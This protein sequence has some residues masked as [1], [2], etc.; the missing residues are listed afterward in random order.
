VAGGKGAS[1]Q[2]QTDESIRRDASLE[3]LGALRPVFREGGSVTAGNSSPLNDGAAAVLLCSKTVAE[4]RGWS[5]MA[6]VLGTGAAGVEPSLM[7]I[8]PVAATRMALRRSNLE[9]SDLDLVELNEAFASQSL[10]CIRE[11]GFDHSRVNVQGGAIALG[12]PIGCSGAR[13]L[14]TLCHALRRRGARYG[15]ATLCIGVGQGL[16]LVIQSA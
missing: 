14:V 5:S 3:K 11:L 1:L 16:A 4:E 13:I 8:G 9:V 2:L 10:A 15:I 6:R 7:G 12:H